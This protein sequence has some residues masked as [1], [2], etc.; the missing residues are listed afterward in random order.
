M[1]LGQFHDYISS[2]EDG[3]VF[4]YGISEPFP[5]EGCFLDVA[6]SIEWNPMSKE[7]ILERISIA[8]GNSFL[9]NEWASTRYNKYSFVFFEESSDCDSDGSYAGE[10]IYYIEN[11][12][13]SKTPEGR[14][15]KLAFNK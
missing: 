2:F 6:F 5:H 8:L 13:L 9:V 14:L 15:V 12:E 7:T 1:N 3:T 4:K 10:C 11:C